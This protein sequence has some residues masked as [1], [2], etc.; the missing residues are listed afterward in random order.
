MSVKSLILG[1]LGKMSSDMLSTKNRMRAVDLKDRDYYDRLNDQDRPK[2]SAYLNMRST[3]NVEGSA[4][5]QEWYLRAHNERVNINFF[6]LS[7]H[8]KLQWLLCT[9]V[10][11]EL[12]VQRHYWLNPK[13][14]DNSSDRLIKFFSELYP[15]Y[16]QQE[17]E[18]MV[19][20]NSLNQIKDFARA[21]GWDERRIKDE[22]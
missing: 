10:S 11:P 9:T 21:L 22:L 13:S 18:L 19:K 6:D 8:P 17:L 5:I 3:A 4:D 2:F 7:R 12:G 16:N 14:R 20:L 1:E 15:E